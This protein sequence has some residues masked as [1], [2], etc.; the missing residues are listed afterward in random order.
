M[1]KA[2]TRASGG[3]SSTDLIYL[4]VD[5]PADQNMP[6]AGKSANPPTIIYFS[7]IGGPRIFSF[8]LLN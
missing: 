6:E 8:V 1:A 3:A 5:W 2:L 7:E 4:A